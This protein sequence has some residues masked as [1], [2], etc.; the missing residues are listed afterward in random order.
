MH[1]ENNMGLLYDDFSG[2]GSKIA[3]F[4][5]ELANRGANPA[6]WVSEGWK[7]MTEHAHPS[8]APAARGWVGNSHIG[9][10]LPVGMK[11]LTLGFAAMQAPSAFAKEDA[12]G[13]GE[14]RGARIGEW[15]GSNA[16]MVLGNFSSK[17]HPI[18]GLGMGLGASIL[19]G[20]AGKYIGSKIS[21]EHGSPGETK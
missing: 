6:K 16:G 18:A 8:T 12:T 13:Q 2:I 20:R 10:H 7:A 3:G 4:G 15:A 5:Q 11:S 14:S 1:S 17:V 9:R 21:G 19:G